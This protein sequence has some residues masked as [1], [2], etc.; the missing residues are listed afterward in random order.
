RLGNAIDDEFPRFAVVGR[1]VRVWIAVVDL[2]EI[3]DRVGGARVEPRRVDAVHG[4]PFRQ[5]RNVLRDVRPAL[6]TVTRHLNQPIVGASP[7]DPFLFGDSAIAI[8]TQAYSTPILSGVRPPEICCRAL[9]LV[10]RSG[11]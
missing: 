10:V 9:S 4:A 8:T 1:F 7:D 11:L 2:M 6:A 5:A 3:E